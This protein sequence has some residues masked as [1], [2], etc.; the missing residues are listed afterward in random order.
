M[1]GVRDLAAV[2][3]VAG[4]GEVLALDVERAGLAAVGQADL[5]AAGDVVADLADRADRVLHREVA[6]HHALLDH[7]QHQ[8]AAGH[9]EHRGRLA[10]VGVAD[11]DVQAAVLLGVGVRLVAGVDDRPATGWWRC[12][13]PSQMCSAR[14]LTAYDAPR[15]GLRDLAGADDDLAGHQERDQH[16]G[17]PA[18]LAGPADQVV[19]VAAVGVAGG[20][21]VVLEQV[22]LARRC[23]RR[24]AAARRRG[25]APRGPAP[26][27]CRG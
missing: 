13:T 6:H 2:D 22:D 27:P 7:P 11:D 25:A 19:L 3:E 24:A 10:H 5:A 15:G 1:I 14:W 23:P 20:V 17:E 12:E 16:V 18:E 26:P 4:L 8:V 9:L 21:G